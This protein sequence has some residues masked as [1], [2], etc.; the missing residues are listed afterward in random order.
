MWEPAELNPGR[1]FQNHF[2]NQIPTK[3]LEKHSM[4]INEMKTKVQ[5][6]LSEL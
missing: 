4:I 3:S 2:C 1:G 6:I 5:N